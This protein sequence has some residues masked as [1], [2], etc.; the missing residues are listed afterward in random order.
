M[1]NRIIHLLLLA[2]SFGLLCIGQSLAADS[3]VYELR[4]Y[5]T[6]EGKLDTLLARFRDHTC[7]LLEKHGIENMLRHYVP[8]VLS[9]EQ[10]EF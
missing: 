2:L 6:N 1:M 4:F 8:E 5:V 3:K 9:V 10:V 7:K